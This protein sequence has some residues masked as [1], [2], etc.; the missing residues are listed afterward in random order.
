MS[1]KIR[2]AFL[3]RRE[4]LSLGLGVPRQPLGHLPRGVMVP[5]VWCRLYVYL[6]G[7]YSHETPN[8]WVVQTQKLWCFGEMSKKMFGLAV[9]FFN[10]VM[11]TGCTYLYAKT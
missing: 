1:N 2:G 10:S 6:P 7:R 9:R 11:E 8:I 5:A 3:G 4:I